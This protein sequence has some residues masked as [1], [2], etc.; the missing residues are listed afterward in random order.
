LAQPVEL[1]ELEKCAMLESDAMRL[2][3][4][5]AIL[6]SH[7]VA[8]QIDP[9]PQ[10]ERTQREV[11][12]EPPKPEV[13]VAATV[14]AAPDSPAETPQAAVTEVET[15]QVA[16]ASAMAVAEV[17]AA[18]TRAAEAPS[19]PSESEPS[20]EPA[21]TMDGWG[22]DAGREP[23]VARASV[24][25]VTRTRYGELVF[26]FDNGQ[27]WRQQEKRYFPYPKDREFDVTITTGMMGEYRLQVEGAGRRTT[28]KRLQ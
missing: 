27:V 16:E 24:V 17:A 9:D 10:A 11:Q 7:G 6:A 18:D 19:V 13:P 1:A 14:D 28:I 22:L 21:T 25:K 26:H 8:R 5:E 15:R 2:A 20:P 23:D 3:C 12:A 4:F